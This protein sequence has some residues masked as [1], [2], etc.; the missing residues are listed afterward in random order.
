MRVLIVD[1]EPMARDYLRELLDPEADVEIVAECADGDEVVAAV[2]R[3]RPEV[4]F[5]DVEMPTCDGIEAARRL[6]AAAPEVRV[7]FVTAHDT[8]A[9]RAFEVHAVDYL[10]KPFDAERLRPTLDRLRLALASRE[11]TA[12]STNDP[13]PNVAAA[14]SEVRRQRTGSGFLVSHAVGRMR[15]IALDEIRWCRAEGNY[16]RVHDGEETHLVRTTLGGLEDQ[17]PADRFARVHRSTLIRVDQ[18]HS[19]ELAG[20]GD[21]RIHLR[22]GTVVNMSRRYRARLEEILG[23]VF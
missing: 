5:L 7:V 22:D 19:L 9:V 13:G 17:L 18:I 6:L 12:S 3:H 14:L 8:F 20:H 15:L 2:A 16:V 4:A 1:D 11:A 21:Y 10:L 23:D